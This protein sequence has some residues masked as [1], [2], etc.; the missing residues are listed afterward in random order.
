MFSFNNGISR[1]SLLLLLVLFSAK[2]KSQ[3][4]DFKHPQNQLFEE[5]LYALKQGDSLA[6]F[7]QIQAAYQLKHTQEAVDYYY[8]VLSLSL[9]KPMADKQALDWFSKTSNKIYQSRISFYLGIYYFRQHQDMTALSSFERTHIDDLD[10]AEILQMKYFQGYLHFKAGNWDKATSLLNAVRQVKE[11]PYYTD[12][13]YYAAFISLERKEF[14]DALSY[15]QIASTNKAYSKLTPFYISQLYYFLGDINAAMRNCETALASQG[16]FYDIQLKQLLGHMLFEKKEYNKALPYLAS[17]LALQQKVDPQDLYQL[18][19]CYFQ[20][21]QWDNAIDGF[22]KLANVEDSLGQNSMY[23]LATSYLKVN[24]K[25]GAKNAF[26]IC[27][28][29]SINLSQKEISL[30]NY[31]KLSVELKDYSNAVY[32]LDKFTTTYP[33]SIYL[34]EAKTL[35]VTS[36]ALNNNFIQALEAYESVENPGMDLLKLYPNILYG[37]STIYINEGQIEKAYILLNQLWNTPYNAKVLPLAQFWI[38][39][40]SYKMGRINESIES[41]EKFLK[42]P[43]EQGEVTQRH[44]RYTLGY[45]YLKKTNYNKASENFQY[46]SNYNHSNR[47]EA[48]QKDAFVR[49]ADCQMMNKQYKLALQSFQKIINEE[50][51]YRDYASLQKAILLGGMNQLDEKIKIL[52]EFDTQFTNSIYKVDALMEL[53]DTYTNQERF[54]EAIAPLTKVLLDKNAGNYYPQAYYKLGIVYFNLNNNQ[55]ALQTFRDL[56]ST[57]PKSTESENSIEFVRNIFVEEQTPELFVEFMNNFGMPLSLNEQDSLTYRASIIKYDQKKYTEAAQGF[58]KYL[59]QFPNGKYQ[60]EANNI[61]AEIAYAQQQ[62]DTAVVYFSNVA[63]QSPNKY[64]ERAALLSARLNYFNLKRYDTA[65]KYFNILALIATQQENKAEAIKGLLRCQYKN[66]KWSDCAKIA[67]QILQDKSAATDDILM[68]NMALYHNSIS[69]KDTSGALQLLT[70]VIKNNSSL[71]TAEAHFLLAKLYFDEGKLA[72]AEKT[73]F[74][75]IQKQASYEYWVTKT[76]ILLGD[77]YTAQKDNFNA[78]ATF[79][80]ISENATIEEF[81]LEAAAKLKALTDNS[82]LK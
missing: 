8:H 5:G 21:Q 63:N 66:K 68:A 43:V 54:Q 28:S 57:Y 26:L 42:D 12:A 59:T 23:L 32:A 65:E 64:A 25:I 34:E 80:S 24:N 39:E 11:N 53:A 49:L 78:I 1:L 71:F 55:V 72:L 41:L 69:N 67:T 44:A 47:I 51:D 82:N 62:Y 70:K 27:S 50:P 2:V 45:C 9:E 48:Y 29:K 56:L 76:Y 75:V 4:F 81:K 36:L 14:K 33:N 79:K 20:A 13:N 30:F 3:S 52:N 40:L 46:V 74:E 31:G 10:N 37:R 60:L 38:G 7:Q 77:I 22:K 61:V 17:Y 15:F 19:F 35:W 18:S 16:Q 58:S 73:A 6:A